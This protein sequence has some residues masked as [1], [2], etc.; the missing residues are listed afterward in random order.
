MLSA[1]IWSPESPG[2]RTEG[3]RK[4]GGEGKMCIS[5]AAYLQGCHGA[6]GGPLTRGHKAYE[7]VLSTKSSGLDEVTCLP[8]ITAFSLMVSYIFS[9]GLSIVPLLNSHYTAQL[10][11]ITW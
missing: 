3:G 5:S 11:C 4:E 1:W 7:V 9:T 10:V 6:V 8:G 2:R